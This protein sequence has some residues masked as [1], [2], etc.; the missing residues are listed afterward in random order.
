MGILPTQD[1]IINA[2]SLGLKN[3]KISLDLSKI[4]KNNLFYDVIYNQVR[5]IF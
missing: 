2:T 4:G 1:V 5:L 3:E